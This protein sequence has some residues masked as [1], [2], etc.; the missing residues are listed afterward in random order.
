MESRLTRP[1]HPLSSF[2]DVKR[3]PTVHYLA[4]VKDVHLLAI[5]RDCHLRSTESVVQIPSSPQNDL[6]GK[7]PKWIR[8]E[9][10]GCIHRV[11]SLPTHLHASSN[12]VTCRRKRTPI[13]SRIVADL[14]DA[15][16][17]L[18]RLSGGTVPVH[19]RYL[20]LLS[21]KTQSFTCPV[22]HNQITQLYAL[23]L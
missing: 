7:P 3:T 15:W 23:R 11:R 18:R 5:F 22:L 1:S 17:G 13:R 21:L 6:V 4:L 2:S 16:L 20:L 8:S 10:I 9:R 12:F 14:D 19:R